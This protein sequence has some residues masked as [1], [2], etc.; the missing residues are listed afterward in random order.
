MKAMKEQNRD[1]QNEFN[2]RVT[3]V[4]VV[5]Y[6]SLYELDSH[7]GAVRCLTFLIECLSLDSR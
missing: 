5:S 6:L 3:Q 2:M 7:P 4:I 1:V